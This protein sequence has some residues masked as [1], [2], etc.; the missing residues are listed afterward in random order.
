MSL[1]SLRLIR[2]AVALCS[3]FM[4][5]GCT[6]TEAGSTVL[7]AD[8]PKVEE[9]N[10]DEDVSVCTPECPF[11]TCGDDGCGGTCAC[12]ADQACDTATK[13]CKASCTPQCE[14]RECGDDGCGGD[15]GTCPGAAPHCSAEGKCLTCLAS[16]E[17]R[18]C[19]DDG[20]GGSCGTCT[21][22]A[23]SDAGQCVACE[24]ECTGKACGGDGCGGSC[25]DCKNGAAC[26]DGQCVACVGSCENKE[27]GDDGCGESCGECTFGTCGN[28]NLC[29]C[30]PSCTDK[31]CGDNGC[32]GTCGECEFGVCGDTGNCQCTPAC[33]GKTCGDDG[34]GGSCGTCQFGSC[35]AAGQCECA[36]SCV[37]GQCGT[38]DGCGGTCTC[39]VGTCGGDGTAGFCG[40]CPVGEDCAIP[41][42][43]NACV[44]GVV[45]CT[46][47]VPECVAANGPD[48]TSCDGGVCT[49]GVC[50]PCIQGATCSLSACE[51]GTLECG[52]GVP[53]CIFAGYKDNGTVCSAGSYCYE[54]SCD[55]CT[56]GTECDIGDECKIGTTKCTGGEALCTGAVKNQPTGTACTGGVC[57]GG[58]CKACDSGAECTSPT[59]GCLVGVIDCSSGAPVCGSFS[60]AVNGTSCGGGNVCLDGA[61]SP[62]VAGTD[63]STGDPCN[64]GQISCGGGSPTCVPT[65]NYAADGTACGTDS[66]C[67][68][69]VC[70]GCQADKT[71]TPSDPCTVGKTSC[72]SGTEQCVPT[73]TPAPDGTAC[74]GG[75][76]Q[77]GTCNPCSA[78]AACVLPDL[79]CMNAEISCETGAPVCKSTGQAVGNGTACG[80]DQY[81]SG[82]TCKTCVEGKVCSVPGKPCRVG[83]TSCASGTETCADSGAYQVDGSACGANQVCKAGDCKGCIAGTTCVPDDECGVGKTECSTGSSKCV[84]SGPKVG[85]E[86]T[87]CGFDTGV[88]HG[89]HCTCAQGELYILGVCATCPDFNNNTISVNA[90]E[91]VGVDNV[92]C[93]RSPAG[94]QLGGP[95]LTMSQ[96]MKNLPGIGF[97]MNVVGDALGNLSSAERYP[98]PLAKAVTVHMPST[99][100]PG[101][102]GV[103]VFEAVE[104]DTTIAI[105]YATI[106]TTCQGGG[107]GAKSGLKVAPSTQGGSPTVSLYAGAIKRC[108]TGLEIRG[109]AASLNSMTLQDNKTGVQ[110]DN[111]TFNAYSSTFSG[112]QDIGI[113]CRSVTDTETISTATLV[114]SYVYPTKQRAIW[115]GQGCNLDISNSYI[116]TPNG[117]ACEP[118]KKGY[119]V[120]V[121]GSAT[122]QLTFNW[123]RC[124]ANDGVSLRQDPTNLLGDPRVVLTSNVIR[125]N[126][127]AGI[128]ADWGEVTAAWG[129]QILSNHYGVHQKG[130]SP[131]A[132]GSINLNGQDPNGNTSRNV[133]ACNSKETPGA[134]CTKA[135]CPNGY[136]ILNNSGTTLIATYN[137]WQESPV[138]F[139]NCNA[140][141]QSCVCAGIAGCSSPPA[142]GIPIVNQGGAS[143]TPKV[144]TTNNA[145]VDMNYC[146]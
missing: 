92:C 66:V 20:C 130:T 25:G 76:C 123:I 44:T 68:G 142:D 7:L 17:G 56:A 9:D 72:D 114:S 37:G 129:N 141:F 73:A 32:G 3:I 5:V 70:S 6:E 39:S 24:P 30:T 16:C 112:Q 74:P 102:P 75:A 40:V 59:N 134:C 10:K 35:G 87:A 81:C 1:R 38:S 23:C 77:S 125:D 14:G 64:P 97:T 4:V 34:C 139:A 33:D 100:A 36:P 50:V 119:G 99:C 12:T 111:A 104:D 118:I 136:D 55:P 96:A 31:D 62:C 27:C 120:Y 95:C 113:D 88:C 11:Q 8:V 15:C 122:V 105:N 89:G 41:G 63:C 133:I 137:M 103:N 146:N 90:N 107:A 108:S 144:T 49:S 58:L 117:I 145:L 46:T 138:G 13:L 98:I 128:Y 101:S 79:P 116:G 83:L 84:V 52:S 143:G 140:L 132:G 57:K 21:D 18:Q 19:G 43:T 109:G 2:M 69:G 29:V 94:G 60:Q 42:N 51:T 67:S 126:G 85:S 86:G 80:G 131:T 121:D 110:I 45:D 53:Q 106:G 124:F 135:N 127:C 91:T 93:G 61:C 115:A 82:G 28:D 47:G 54:G 78:G 26:A 22:G 48:G 71:C 65:G